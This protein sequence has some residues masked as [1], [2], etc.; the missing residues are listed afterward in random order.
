MIA[1]WRSRSRISQLERDLAK[2]DQALRTV[3]H[4]AREIESA[5]AI[6][7]A[8]HFGVNGADTRA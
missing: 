5:A 1:P 6:Q 4:H 8:D 7:T 2:R 3:K